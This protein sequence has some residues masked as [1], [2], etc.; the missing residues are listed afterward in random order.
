MWKKLGVV[1]S[2]R[3]PGFSPLL[4]N[5]RIVA[6]GERLPTKACQEI[7]QRSSPIHPS[8]STRLPGHYEWVAR[9]TPRIKIKSRAFL[10]Q[11]P[12][13]KV[14]VC[15]T[16][17]P[18]ACHHSLWY[19]LTFAE[20]GCSINPK[21]VLF[22]IL[23]PFKQI[24]SDFVQLNSIGI[25]VRDGSGFYVWRFPPNLLP[26]LV[27]RPGGTFL[28]RLIHPTHHPTPTAHLTCTEHAATCSSLKVACCTLWEHKDV[29]SLQ[30][31]K[32]LTQTSQSR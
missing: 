5:N 16:K 30:A 32:H 3:A 26:G 12:R 20:D 24:S 28:S 27:Q 4:K 25:R 22:W 29:Q 17:S 21:T 6:F 8:L 15:V 19:N 23:Y 1:L 2:N 10:A 13:G 18:A 7:A 31:L 9:A 11:I 14:R